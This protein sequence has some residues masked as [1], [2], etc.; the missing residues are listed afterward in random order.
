MLTTSWPR[1]GPALWQGMSVRYMGT[2]TPC[3]TL[4]TSRPAAISASSK[5]N[6]QPRAKA[7]KSSCHRALMSS[8]S[9]L[10]TPARKTRY[11][12]M[13]E[14]TSRL[15]R[16]GRRGSPGFSLMARSGQ[17]RGL[18]WQKRKK[19]SAQLCASTTRLHCT[20]PG[21]S[22][23]VG[24]RHRPWRIRRRSSAGVLA[25]LADIVNCA[26]VNCAVV[27]SLVVTGHRILAIV[28]AINRR[29][30]R[31]AWPFD[32]LSD[33]FARTCRSQPDINA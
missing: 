21:A 1:N 32:S 26:V 17:G 2:F 6:E 15:P 29:A 10:S 7:T 28:L 19:L 33:P 31:A 27:T 13:S 23:E 25:L 14:R 11:A 5:E 8:H 3:V 16:P 18:A 30:G 9:S 4:R 12:G 24:R 22:P 20:K